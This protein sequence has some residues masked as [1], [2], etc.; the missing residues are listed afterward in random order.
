MGFFQQSLIYGLGQLAVQLV[1]FLIYPILTNDRFFS[2]EDFGIWNILAP[3]MTIMTIIYSGGLSTGFFK[4]FINTE[5]PD[6]RY[7]AFHSSMF[8]VAVFGVIT[9]MITLPVLA[10]G[11]RASGS[12]IQWPYF[13]LAMVTAFANAVIGICLAVYR[14]QGRAKQFVAINSLR[15]V[16][17]SL[18]IAIGVIIFQGGLWGL[19]I[20]YSA[21]ATLVGIYLTVKTFAGF[22]KTA[23]QKNLRSKI[24]KFSLPLMPTQLAGWILSVSDKFL[25]GILL[26][27]TEVGLYSA[28]YQIALVTNAFFIGPF[29]LAWGPFMF[30]EG[31]KTDG[32]LK[33]A[34]LLEM[35]T[36]IGGIFVTPLIFLG[37]EI[38]AFLNGNI[39]YVPSYRVIPPVAL[40]YLFFG[41]YLF[42]S[43]GLN[44]TNRTV[45][46]PIITGSVGILNITLNL[47][48]LPRWGY[49][50]AAW[51]T[52]IS[53]FTLFIIMK[54][55]TA[56][57]Y[58]IPIKK[59]TLIGIW[60]ILFGPVLGGSY[61][62]QST[63]YPIN[64]AWKLIMIFIIWFV[65]IFSS[66]LTRTRLLMMLNFGVRKVE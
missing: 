3:T 61:W 41:Y 58:H 25:I 30:R 31:V 35:Y 28:G 52:L 1:G 60:G 15:F 33:I 62:V 27:V 59:L 2:V 34:R 32:P 13:A 24:L 39:T 5:S 14:A 48:L 42:Y 18:L 53:Y 51:V 16:L 10:L 7:S 64:F 40:G 47:I 65:L 43:T 26:G 19:L 44:L 66:D 55:S 46:F 22:Q 45:Y 36:I 57:L 11:L 21:S 17:M 37:P 4:F 54:I 6:Q 20:A 63:D 23:I 29:S 49:V 12:S 9:T 8:I 56:K 38:I 50:A